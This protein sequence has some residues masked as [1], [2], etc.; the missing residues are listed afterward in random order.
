MPPHLLLMTKLTDILVKN[1][2]ATFK[3]G[4]PATTK[5]KETLPSDFIS[6]QCYSLDIAIGPG[7]G[8]PVG[9]M[10][11]I[12][13]AEQSG[14]TTLVT[15]ILAECQRRGGVSLLLDTENKYEAEHGAALG[16]YTDEFCPPDFDG[17][18]LV[19]I[20]PEHIKEAFARMEKFVKDTRD[21]DKDVLIAIAWDSVAATMTTD[22]ASSENSDYESANP[23]GAAAKEISQALKRF[24]NEVVKPLD[25]AFIAVN[26]LKDKINTGFGGFGDKTTTIASKPLGF[27]SSV[28][29]VTAHA[30]FIVKGG[31]KA[32]KN[33][34][35]GITV[36]AKVNK[37]QIAPPHREANFNI[38]Y[39]NGIDS[40]GSV[41]ETGI[42]FGVIKKN[43]GFLK[44][45][46][47][48]FRRKQ[49]PN[50][51]FY[52]E[53]LDAIDE[54]VT[55]KQRKAVAKWQAEQQARSIDADE[56]ESRLEDADEDEDDLMP[57]GVRSKTI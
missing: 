45:G 13:G 6:T 25:V 57:H 5:G 16:L 46:E 11:T 21:L 27:Y 56:D 39:D 54:A 7:H 22:E 41:L 28:R 20:Y 2:N 3:G 15:Q 23:F 47:Q 35:D 26:Q 48:Q 34:S 38:Y 10:T 12:Q 17:N 52:E 24:V 31:G 50:V 32:S 30:G 33:E 19:I 51:E 8:I 44:F 55:E 9:R 1:Q 42:V 29:I 18:P 43:G 36:L 37:N 14:K 49:W 53:A 4:R 40:D